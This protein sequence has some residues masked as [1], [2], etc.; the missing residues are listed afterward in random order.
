MSPDHYE[1]LEYVPDDYFQRACLADVFP[2]TPDA[3]SEL[4]LGSGD[5]GFL[6]AM[7]THFPNRNFLGVERLLGRVR[8]SARRALREN[9][10]NVRLLR[11]DSMYAVHWLLPHESFAR[12]HFLFPDPWPK[13]RHHRRRLFQPEF[14]RAIHKLLAPCGELLF[15]TDHQEYFQHAQAVAASLGDFFEVPWASGDFFYPQTDFERQWR[16]EGREIWQ[17]RLKKVQ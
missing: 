8:S 17:L 16:S 9:L 1:V 12:I 11:L 14:L 4:D 6:L 15:K 13:K 10:A 2:H 7:A 3:P 5:G